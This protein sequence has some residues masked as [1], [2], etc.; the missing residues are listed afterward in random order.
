MERDTY[1]LFQV[2]RTKAGIADNVRIVKNITNQ[3]RS[4]DFEF[5]KDTQEAELL[6]SARKEALWS[7]L[8]LR[9][10]GVELWG[11]DT[12]V[13]LADIIEASKHETDQLGLS[14]SILGHV[15]DGNFH[16]SILYDNRDPVERAK[17]EQCVRN[18]V[19]RALDMEGTCTVS[20]R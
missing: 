9:K 7:M 10:E 20:S 8:A 4:D 17:V 3:F 14:A 13:P 18:M 6:W 5:A 2:F 16:A 1:T 12:A 11:T 19:D 15:G